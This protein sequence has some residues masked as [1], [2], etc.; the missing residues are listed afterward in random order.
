MAQ[1]L[2]GPG[3]G[4]QGLGFDPPPPTSKS[5]SKNSN[6]PGKPEKTGS[7]RDLLKKDKKDKGSK[8]KGSGTPPGFSKTKKSSTPDLSY[9]GGGPD[10]SYSSSP[11]RPVTSSSGSQPLG[12]GLVAALRAGMSIEQLQ[13]QLGG[14]IP[15]SQIEFL[16]KA[17]KAE[18]EKEKA[19]A[20]A[21][22]PRPAANTSAASTPVTSSFT[23]AAPSSTMS[24]PSTTSESSSETS[25]DDSKD[26]RTAQKPLRT[27]PAAPKKS[28]RSDENNPTSSLTAGLSAKQAPNPAQAALVAALAA[29]LTTSATP[30]L[31]KT[32]SEKKIGASAEESNRVATS[33]SSSSI[34][35]AANPPQPSGPAP[36]APAAPAPAAPASPPQPATPAPEAPAPTPA[37]TPAPAPAPTPAVAPAPAVASPTP[38]PAKAEPKA[39][40]FCFSCGEKFPTEKARFCP[41]CGEARVFLSAPASASASSETPAP[42]PTPAPAQPE[43]TPEPAAEPQ[44]T[45]APTSEST[46]PAPAHPAPEAPTQS[47][48]APAEE[49]TN[50]LAGLDAT[51]LSLLSQIPIDQLAGVL[52]ST[53]MPQDQIDALMAAQKSLLSSQGAE[54]SEE[55]YEESVGD[56]TE[57]PE[58]D[59]D[60]E[61]EEPEEQAPAKKSSVNLIVHF[62]QLITDQRKQGVDLFEEEDNANNIQSHETDQLVVGAPTITNAQGQQVTVLVDSGSLPKLIQRLTFEKHPDPN[63]LSVFMLTYHAFTTPTE[64]LELLILRYNTPPPPGVAPESWERDKQIP[65]RLRVVNVLRHWLQKFNSDF[66]VDPA[67]L[68]R[69]KGFVE[70]AADTGKMQRIAAEQLKAL[71]VKFEKEPLKSPIQF[72]KAPPNP[73]IPSVKSLAK[74]TIID[75]HYVELARQL[76]LM[77]YDLFKQ[78]NP[79]EYLKQ[80][81]KKADKMTR[82]PNICAMI[83]RF[84]LVSAWVSTEV[85]KA[86]EAKARANI[87]AKFI[88]VAEECRVLQNYNGMMEIIAGL[89]NASVK[90][91]KQTWEVLPSKSWDIWERLKDLV[92]N[93][94][95][96]T[97][98]RT[99][100][101]NS[102]PPCIPYLGLNLSDLVFLEDG[103]PDILQEGLLVNFAKMRMCA[104]I[105][106]ELQHFQQTPYCLHPV[107]LIQ[108]YLSKLTVLTDKD[109]YKESLLREKG[110]RKA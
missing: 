61:Q 46:P 36:A 47:A 88:N 106:I 12:G 52:A 69:L 19:A 108:E 43:P 58:E 29:A 10:L 73:H 5:S 4:P 75:I 110:N 83:D 67:L 107:P 15:Q 99:T 44:P 91:L 7:L 103:N 79:S 64:L 102:Q 3:D 21:M 49:A 30:S 16:L 94:A 95:N 59:D 101:K 89:Q 56:T 100:L 78:A 25:S 28:P 33:N 104:N 11:S 50:P 2:F 68:N 60:G 85:V 34:N 9:G 8:T 18:E 82:S 22:A 62:S 42:A 70:E 109:L 66:R 86:T 41:Y 105:I 14:K 27:P 51:I 55:T 1:G 20:A 35:S 74:L 53:G 93:E 32:N 54:E 31:L 96:F 48:D 81:W 38:A 39:A 23:T 84:N 6:K 98:Y 71:I 24:S 17:V 57:E 45:P 65:I 72:S 77:E 90:R 92:K 97:N 76:T 40:A 37:P 87:I 80:G 63:F 13:A 26:Q